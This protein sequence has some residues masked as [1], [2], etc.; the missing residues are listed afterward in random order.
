VHLVGSIPLRD[1]REV[2]E[3]TADVLGRHVRRMPDGETGERS[4]WIQ[5]QGPRLEHNP[6]LE[7][8]PTQPARPLERVEDDGR[9]TTQQVHLFRLKSGV[10]G[11]QLNFD[12]GYSDHA[13]VSYDV[14]AELQSAGRIPAHARFQVSIPTP[15]AITLAYVSPGSHA[16]FGRAFERELVHEVRRIC[17]QVP[18]ERLAIQ[19]DVCLEVLA[20]EGVIPLAD[21]ETVILN[22]LRRLGAAVPTDVELGFHLCYGDPGHK[23]VV[24]PKD[25][26]VLVEIANGLQRTA[27][28]T[29][30]WIHMPVPRERSD[31]DYFAALAGLERLP[32]LELYLGLVHMTDGVEGARARIEAAQKAVAD[33]GIATEC[34]FGRRPRETMRP[35]MQLHAD[36]AEP[37][38]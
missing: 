34:G 26:R 1:T 33:F 22:Q 21:H 37:I 27:T 31:D 9:I 7:R 6:G 16:D 4:N 38:A 2:F 20:W 5:W 24:E 10:S 12:T 18:H 35:L 8:D 15:L 11:D 28:R 30:Q 14:F 3:T 29:V 17:D 19:W 25:T 36:L 32:G 13:L 23:H